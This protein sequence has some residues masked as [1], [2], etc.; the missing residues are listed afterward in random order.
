MTWPGFSPSAVGQDRI[1]VGAQ[2]RR[3]AIARRNRVFDP[4]VCP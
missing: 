2:L 1:D 3:S 4:G